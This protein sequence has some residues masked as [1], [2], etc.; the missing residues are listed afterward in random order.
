MKYIKI[1]KS[2]IEYCPCLQPTK[3]F[4]CICVDICFTVNESVVLAPGGGVISGRP[5]TRA[6]VCKNA[7][8]T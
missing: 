3:A 6:Q 4:A 1:R 8:T 5:K 2:F 7:I